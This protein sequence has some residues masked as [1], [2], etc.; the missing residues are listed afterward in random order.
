[1]PQKNVV[2]DSW[3]EGNWTDN[4]I[5]KENLDPIPIRT[6]GIGRLELKIR[7][8][9]VLIG[10]IRKQN[11]VRSSEFAKTRDGVNIKLKQIEAVV[12]VIMAQRETH[13][14]YVMNLYQLSCQSLSN[15]C[16]MSVKIN[17][18]AA[19]VKSATTSHSVTSLN[20]YRDFF[21]GLCMIR[22]EN[23]KNWE[24]AIDKSHRPVPWRF[25][26]DD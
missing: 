16:F 2:S 23:S 24:F 13:D 14:I 1:M 20:I 22:E 15:L 5:L 19:L 7:F 18:P 21:K 9:S 12:S 26:R 25:P 6:G 3:N 4:A 11:G 10:K 8:T 17:R